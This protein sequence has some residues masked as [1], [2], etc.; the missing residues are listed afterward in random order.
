MGIQ[1]AEL[2][3]HALPSHTITFTA[4]NYNI[5]SAGTIKLGMHDIC[6]TMANESTFQHER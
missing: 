3:H 5:L 6:R 4:E 2:R 1:L